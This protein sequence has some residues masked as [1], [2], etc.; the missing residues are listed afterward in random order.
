MQWD[1]IQLSKKEEN[2]SI[3]DNMDE[4]GGHYAEWNKPDTETQILYGFTYMSNFKKP[5]S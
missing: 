3:C 4:P 2:P 1:I 5:N